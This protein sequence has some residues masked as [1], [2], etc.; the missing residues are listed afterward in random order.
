MGGGTLTYLQNSK[1]WNILEIYK[2]KILWIIQPIFKDQAVQKSRIAETSVTTK[3]RC[4]TSPKSEHLLL[5][6]FSCFM[7]TEITP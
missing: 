4:V 7:S 5:A 6:Y 3:P 1:A 2:L